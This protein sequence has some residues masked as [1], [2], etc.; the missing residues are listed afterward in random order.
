MNVAQLRH[1]IKAVLDEMEDIYRSNYN[2]PEAVELLIMTA[3]CESDMGEYIMQVKGPAMGIFQMEPAT[4][5]DLFENWLCYK[6]LHKKVVER[7]YNDKMTFEMN[8][9][10]NLPYQIAIARINYMRASGNIPKDIEGM[11]RYYKRVWNTVLGKG[12][13]EGAVKDYLRYVSG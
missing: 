1:L 2:S 11:G 7:F 9:I 3:A 6:G 4:H 8:L 13:A 12:S 5:R 10:G